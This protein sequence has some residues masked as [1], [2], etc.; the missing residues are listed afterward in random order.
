MIK[1]IVPRAIYVHYSNH[2]LDLVIAEACTLQVV[3][4]FFGTIR[5]VVSFINDSPKRK[6]ILAKAIESTNDE[7]KRR[8]LVKLCKTRWVDK[9]ISIFVFKEAYFGTI[10]ALDHLIDNGDSETS[11]LVRSYQKALTDI[12]FAIPLIIV[13]RLFCSSTY[14]IRRSH[15]HVK[16]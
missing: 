2:S 3:K 6:T 4:P 12:D 14:N 1:D 5:A 13:N 10:V 11:G 7:T 8:H 16:H 9:H 15:L